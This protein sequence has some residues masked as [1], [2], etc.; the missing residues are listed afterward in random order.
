[1]GPQIGAI[2]LTDPANHS[3]INSDAFVALVKEQKYLVGSVQTNDQGVK[4]IPIH[5]AG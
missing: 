1:M 5:K 2:V 3:H 4:Y